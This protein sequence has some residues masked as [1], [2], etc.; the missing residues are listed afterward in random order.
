MRLRHGRISPLLAGVAIG[1][2]LIATLAAPTTLAAG[3]KF[4]WSKNGNKATV[5]WQSFADDGAYMTVT[6]TGRQL[7]GARNMY[8][9][10][11]FYALRCAAGMNTCSTTSVGGVVSESEG[12]EWQFIGEKRH[13]NLPR[14]KSRRHTA[15]QPL[16]PDATRMQARVKLC[17]DRNITPDPC[18]PPRYGNLTYNT[19]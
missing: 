16:D 4:S 8:I 2:A 6:A 14:K 12:A 17:Y 19:G 11:D 13:K 3:N 9:R 1:V 18:S 15:S 10:V 7:R 5:F